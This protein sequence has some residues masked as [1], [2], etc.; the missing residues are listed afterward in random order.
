MT[1]LLLQEDATHNPYPTPESPPL[2]ERPDQNGLTPLAIAAYLGNAAMVELLVDGGGD[3]LS[4]TPSWAVEMSA[5]DH[6]CFSPLHHAASQGHS[7]VV[8]ILGDRMLSSG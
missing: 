1:K 7:A 3:Q 8:R 5:W 6:Y 2:L 4:A